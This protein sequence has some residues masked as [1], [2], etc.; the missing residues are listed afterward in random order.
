MPKDQFLLSV[1]APGGYEKTIP[2]ENGR[3]SAWGISAEMTLTGSEIKLIV[4]GCGE[5]VVTLW[6][7][8]G[9]TNPFPLL[10]AFMIGY[11]RPDDTGPGY[12][13]L[14]ET[15]DINPPKLIAPY[16]SI[17]SDRASAPVAFIFGDEGMRALA[18]APYIDR[19]GSHTTN[20]LRVCKSRGIG[21]SIGHI[22][23]PV[24]FVHNGVC[25]P[26]SRSYHHFNKTETF[27]IA[28]FSSNSPDRRSHANVI[29]ELYRRDHQT[30]PLGAGIRR[31]TQLLADALVNDIL[32]PSIND[33]FAETGGELFK[34]KD[35]QRARILNEIGWTGGS[36]VAYPCLTLQ[37]RYPQPELFDYAVRRLNQICDSINP[38]SGLFWDCADKTGGHA[39]GWW[40]GL[41]PRAHYSY[42]QGHACYYLLK[43]AEELRRLR[44]DETHSSIA[45]KWI[46]AAAAV[47]ERILSRQLDNGQFPVS[48]SV[49]TGEPLDTVGFAGCWF[50]PALALLYRLRSD[51]RYLNA[52]IRA[53]VSYHRDIIEMTP[54]ATPMDTHRATDQEGNLALLQAACILHQITTERRFI[55]MLKDSADYEM[56]WRYYYN[57]RAP[58]PPLTTAD[59]GSS[60]GSVTS[61]HNPHIHPMQLNAL[62]PV[63]YL[64]DQTGDAYYLER[65]KDAI[66]Y[67]C[68]CVC[69]DGE[70]FGWGKPGWLCERFCPSDG[71]VVQANLKTGEPWSAGCDYHPWTVAVTLEGLTGEVWDRFPELK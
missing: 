68:C 56:L 35:R 3:A 6:L 41:S 5:A 50:V 58:F 60:G 48:L 30:A 27:H 12:P 54:C 59:W 47:L 71:L 31:T 37:S 19:P 55:D 32:R 52:A 15:L 23:E 67:G 66:R 40:V 53:A 20:G 28:R 44:P 43:S 9:F 69:R 45:S 18:I 61:A 26:G 36:M 13:Q 14:A 34:I 63:L 8:P 17:R 70:D 29:K 33:H 51:S 22:V 49:E 39:K 57:V 2:F 65:T 24:Q 7:Q 62:E 1:L 46:N 38:A 4:S 10:P 21:I 16:W 25:A 64:Y 42:V 11:N